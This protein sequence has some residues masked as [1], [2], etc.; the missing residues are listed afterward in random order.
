MQNF[1]IWISFIPF[2]KN[3]IPKFVCL[4]RRGGNTYINSFVT[5]GLG[6]LEENFERKYI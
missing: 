1:I 6:E 4:P 5:L 3:K 2:L